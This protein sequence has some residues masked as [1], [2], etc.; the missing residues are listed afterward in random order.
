MIDLKF[1]IELNIILV[2]LGL[3]FVLIK[4]K[5]SVI[6]ARLTLV[7]LPILAFAMMLFKSSSIG[8][9]S[10]IHV[11]V[12]VSDEIVISSNSA[13]QS[14]LF[15]NWEMIFVYISAL[16]LVILLFRILRLLFQFRKASTLISD[17]RIKVLVSDKKSSFS[18]F[19]RVHLSAQLDKDEQ[20]VVLEHE[21]LHYE[22]L[23][24]LDMILMEIYHALFWYNP[25]F[26]LL[27]RE[28]VQIHE[29]EVDQVMFSRHNANYLRH[30]L[31]HSLGASVAHLLLT[32][33]FKSKSTLAKRIKKMKNKRVTNKFALLVVPIIAITFSLISWT[34][35]SSINVSD[36]VFSPQ[37]TTKKHP[38]QMPGYNPEFRGGF[39]ALVAFINANLKYPEE[40]EKQNIQGT[41][42]VTFNVGKAGEISHVKAMEGEADELLVN[43]AVR[44]VAMMPNWDPA[45]RDGKAVAVRTTLPITFSLDDTKPKTIKMH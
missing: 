11:P 26:I 9:T 27:K 21:I 8:S 38:S 39:E 23:H 4:N 7:F 14:V 17:E 13:D 29:Y 25:I 32:S 31:A 20:N 15:F 34:D 28:L 35:S 16:L 12:F 37:D 24:S 10:S 5:I 3:A 33:Q 19:N 36:S 42:Y 1:V 6:T 30:L 43:E 41:V 40:A 45:I 22:N 2:V 18:F 44:V